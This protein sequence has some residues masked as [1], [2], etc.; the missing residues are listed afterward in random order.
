MRR[1]ATKGAQ[2]FRRRAGYTLIEVLMAIGV[3]AAGSVAIMAMHQAATRGNM[4]ARQMTTGNQLAQRWVER[5]RRDGLNWTRSSNQA[6]DP[7]LLA[8]T[9]YLQSV[10]GP[11]GAP[12]WFVPTPLATSG[13]TANFD[14]YGNDLGG[15]TSGTPTY[16]TNV[17]L[18]WLYPG[19]ALRADV[20][21]W[22]V[23]RV[24]GSA[25]APGVAALAN[26]APGVDPNALT[27]NPNV[28][29]VYTSTVI[30]YI[31]TSS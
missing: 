2:R 23:R 21:V 26:C 25:P 24:A 8:Q 18:E 14:Y 22:W 12:S 1:A 13:E 5:L 11:G 9:T 7:T 20:R 29:M 6:F 4:E 16:C 31:P 15:P 17:R 27:N 10:P 19:R 30:R 3:L 28:R